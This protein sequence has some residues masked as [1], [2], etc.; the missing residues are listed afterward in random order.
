[1]SALTTGARSWRWVF[2]LC[3]LL[4]FAMALAPTG[5]GED[6]FPQADKLRHALA[7]VA[8]WLLGRRAGL[9]SGWALALVLVGFGAAI[10][11]AQ[12]LTAYR[13]ASLGDLAADV[14]GVALGWWL[15]PVRRVESSHPA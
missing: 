7:F 14:L 4:A 3:L 5:G 11:L 8:L 10:E 2:W 1:M 13:Q 6:W 9:S 15:R 12:G